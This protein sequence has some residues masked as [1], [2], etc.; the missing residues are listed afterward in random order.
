MINSNL[1]DFQKESIYLNYAATSF[2]KSKIALESF[3]KAVHTL[4]GSRQNESNI[5]YQSFRGRI[6]KILNAPAE[7]VFFTSS[8]TIGLNQVIKGFA[9][10]G[11]CLAIDN[12]SHNA[13]IRPWVSLKDK[14]QC[15]IADLYDIADNF[16]EAN[17]L[18][19]LSKGP[20]L[21]CLTHVSN[22]NGSIYP[23]EKI[24]ELVKL[25]SPTTSILIDASQSAGA[26]SLSTLHN[27]DFVVFPSHKH[28]HSL[29]GAA[30]VV[31]RK[32]LEPI[33]FGGTG[34]NSLA[35]ETLRK[36][37]IFAEVG[38]MNFPAIQALVDSLEY[39]ESHLQTHRKLENDLVTQFIEGIN[40]INGLQLIGRQASPHRIGIVAL[41][42]EVGSA[43]LHWVPF[44]KSQKIF[45][46]GGLHCS[47]L[48]HLQLSLSTT[49][50]L[51]FS[52]GWSS[53]SEHVVKA[54]GAIN[55]FNDVVRR[56][57]D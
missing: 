5:Y 44:L 8:A 55:E 50:T 34:A 51:R 13:V 19:I 23:V 2:P 10:E 49:G 11:S 4:P 24:I 21:L 46:R 18:E 41:K 42:T 25:L 9:K 32:R 36:E 33:I 38:T 3:L 17:L 43:E 53:T 12:R 16:I 15:L 45:V 39:A 52:F 20:H 35:T 28:L 1:S 31:A 48:H 26:L 27:A 6:G 47:P 54:L 22:V 7:N 30:V 56:F 40:Q 57:H 29:P 37:E 14:C